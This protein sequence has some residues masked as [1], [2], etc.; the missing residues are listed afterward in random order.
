MVSGSAV[1]CAIT[2]ALGSG[3]VSVVGG[4]GG[5][6]GAAAT[7]A[8]FLH[9]AASITAKQT[10]KIVALNLLLNSFLQFNVLFSPN[11]HLIP[12]LARELLDVFPIGQH[13]KNLHLAAVAI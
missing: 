5:G 2:G 11:W 6:G 4:G 13:C 3:L 10:I 8:F 12:A 7:G 9:P 1:N